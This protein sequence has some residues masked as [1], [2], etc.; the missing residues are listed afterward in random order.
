MARGGEA[1]DGFVDAG[2]TIRGELEFLTTFRLEGRV[3]GTVRSPA[4]LVIGS[5]GVVEGEI[6]VARCLVAGT[7]RGRIAA[8]ERVVLHAGARVEAD[9][10]SPVVVMEDGAHLVGH[11]AMKSRD[12]GSSKP[13]SKETA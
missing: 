4:E 12:E 13:L 8:T 5:G 9:L 1:L 2:C 11:V 6:H 3:E 10:Q 7:V